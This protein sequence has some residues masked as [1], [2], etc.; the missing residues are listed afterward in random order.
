MQVGLAVENI[1]GLLAD[2]TTLG[3]N[4]GVHAGLNVGITKGT[5]VVGANDGV[6]VGLNV[7]ITEGGLDDGTTLAFND[8]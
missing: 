2:R 7:G 3:V 8:G 4:D 6:H 1:K 5:I